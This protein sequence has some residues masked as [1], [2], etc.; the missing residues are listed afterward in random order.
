MSNSITLGSQNRVRTEVGPS[1]RY[2]D[3]DLARFPEPSERRLRPVLYFA[4]P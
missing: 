2:F 3:H 1:P 4:N